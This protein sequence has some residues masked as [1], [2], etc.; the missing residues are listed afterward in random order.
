MQSAGRAGGEARPQLV[1]LPRRRRSRKQLVLAGGMS[2]AASVAAATI[3]LGFS[4]S[5][6]DIMALGPLPGVAPAEQVSR[7]SDHAAT[8]PGRRPF[9]V[10]DV[11]YAT[12][13]FGGAGAASPVAIPVPAQ[14]F[15]H[16]PAFEIGPAAGVPAASSMAGSLPAA[17]GAPTGTTTAVAEPIITGPPTLPV[18]ALAEQGHAPA[19]PNLAYPA[20]PTAPILAAAG[21]VPAERVPQAPVLAL[22]P[23]R[24]AM[25]L[26]TA[27]DSPAAAAP[28]LAESALPEAPD[29]PAR[30]IALA[31]AINWTQ[32][33]PRS[34]GP[35]PA[36]PL[37]I[38]AVVPFAT[39][40]LTGLDASPAPAHSE[41][42]EKPP[43]P[44][45]P[46]G[47]A[48]AEPAA[49][50]PVGPSALQVAS[51]PPAVMLPQVMP[52]PSR[53]EG[54]AAKQH[55]TAAVAKRPPAGENGPSAQQQAALQSTPG[56][57]ANAAVSRATRIDRTP[58]SSP[59]PSVPD[60]ATSHSP[61][62]G[63]ADSRCVAMLA[64]L[65]LDEE[66]TRADRMR[67][68]AACS[69]S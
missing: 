53:R 49:F 40:G 8:L 9:H 6:P 69:P 57:A 23:E 47:I 41:Q 21:A 38:V 35:V 39:A 37:R 28:I 18:A 45:V 50:S 30:P 16:V 61:T 46:A 11:R 68:R 3:F 22:A 10:P 36:P 60:R 59:T 19:P 31:A 67:L 5:G 44:A 43:P 4:A 33:I 58:P 20:T 15:P 66:P 64:R 51:L 7:P 56:S 25:A 1:A 62:T 52:V 34:I 14:G 26:A 32:M 48:T 63:R 13:A 65:Q 12:T 2:A 54:F 29:A 27:L 42:W 24:P 55:P 17:E